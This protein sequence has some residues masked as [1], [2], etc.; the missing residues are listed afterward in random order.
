MLDKVVFAT[1]KNEYLKGTYQ[2]PSDIPKTYES[3][4]CDFTDELEFAVIKKLQVELKY[5]NSKNLL[6]SIRGRI[7][8]IFTQNHEEFLQMSNLTKVRLD[9][10]ASVHILNVH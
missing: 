6:H 5:W 3:V 2:N 1:T 4:A 7:I 8:D 10:I 9:R